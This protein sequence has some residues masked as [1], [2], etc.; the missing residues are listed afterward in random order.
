MYRKRGWKWALM[1][2][3]LVARYAAPAYVAL[4]VAV[5][6]RGTW[7]N[8]S[9]YN[10]GRATLFLGTLVSSAATCLFGLRT[11]SMWCCDHFVLAIVVFLAV[12][13]LVVNLIISSWLRPFASRG[14][15]C[16]LVMPH[17]DAFWYVTHRH[18]VQPFAEQPGR[19]TDV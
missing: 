16:V 15:L 1:P 7:T 17:H 6:R 18:I 13:Q 12:A 9:C 2:C 11:W 10:T 3:F 14:G 4:C 19:A 5:V 8:Q